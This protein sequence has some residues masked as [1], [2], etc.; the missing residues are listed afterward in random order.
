MCMLINGYSCS[1]RNQSSLVV[2]FD[3]ATVVPF[4]PFP[5]APPG[6]DPNTDMMRTAAEV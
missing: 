2:G 5:P 1:G 4:S 6:T 3:D